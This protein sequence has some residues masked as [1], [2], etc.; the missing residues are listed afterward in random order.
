MALR[1]SN[2]F[3]LSAALYSLTYLTS[4]SGLLCLSTTWLSKFSRHM[5]AVSDARTALR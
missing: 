2:Y 3:L 5:A 4:T 1:M